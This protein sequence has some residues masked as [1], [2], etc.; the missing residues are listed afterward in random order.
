M[1]GYKRESIEAFGYATLHNPD[2]AITNMVETLMC[3][4]ELFDG[5]EDV[6]IAYADIIYEPRIVKAI[7]ECTASLSTL[8]DRQWLRLW[9][10]RTEDPLEDAET[11]RMDEAGNIT[12]LGKRPEGLDEIEGQYMGLIKIAKELAS[13]FLSQYDGL[14]PR[15]VYDGKNLRNMY[16]TS[17]LQHLVDNG[18]PM[19]AVISDGGWIEVD[20]VEDLELYERLAR[21]GELR[22]FVDL[23]ACI[24]SEEKR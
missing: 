21:D 3:A 1:T 13:V 22:E 20:T 11:L 15:A 4:R 19:R 24:V 6:L 9:E 12:E 17:F 16:M 5:S 7:A 2:Y 8:V 18:T 10:L 14:D 23:Q